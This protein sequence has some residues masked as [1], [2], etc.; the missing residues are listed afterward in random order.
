MA[1]FTLSKTFHIKAKLYIL[2]EKVTTFQHIFLLN[3][4]NLLMS[5]FANSIS[6]TTLQD[7]KFNNKASNLG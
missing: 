6:T 7:A 3:S 5:T 4:L 1:Y 2:T